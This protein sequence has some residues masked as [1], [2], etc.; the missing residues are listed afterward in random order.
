MRGRQQAKLSG[1]GGRDGIL[2]DW[3]EST[4]L[5]DVRGW[6]GFY[7]L[8]PALSVLLALGRQPHAS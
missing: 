6:I 3:G 2:G 7:L 1:N 4:S 8:W 5:Q